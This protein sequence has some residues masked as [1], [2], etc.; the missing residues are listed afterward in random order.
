MA[1]L[2]LALL[3]T[4]LPG[5]N[6]LPF[7]GKVSDTVPG[8][9]PPSQRIA[10]LK[11]LATGAVPKDPADRER[12]A[13]ELAATCPRE[14]DPLI[15]AATVAALGAYPGPAALAAL[16]GAAKDSEPGVRIAVCKALARQRGPEATAML[17]QVFA[18]DV[19]VDVRL[20]AA[21]ALGETRDPAA[22]ATLGA[23]LEDRDPAMQYRAVGSLRKVAPQDLGNDVE[24]WRQYV[25]GQSGQPGST[26]LLAEPIRR[27]Y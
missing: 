13:S 21:R 10:D 9:T 3:G 12:I 1:A 7:A 15:R 27:S 4:A 19:D 11:K 8:I 18:G 20:A 23:A 17:R 25:E 22:V 14:T 24:R 5:C 26:P 6:S 16:A 2:I